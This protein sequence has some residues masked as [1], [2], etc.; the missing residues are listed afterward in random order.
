MILAGFRRPHPRSRGLSADPQRWRCLPREHEG[1]IS[2]NE[3][4]ALLESVP[5]DPTSVYRVAEPVCFH[6]SPSLAYECPARCDCAGRPAD[7]R[8][9]PRSQPGETVART[10]DSGSGKTTLLAVL[11]ASRRPDEGAVLVGDFDLAEVDTA[12]WQA[13]V[14]RLPQRP[15]LFAGTLAHIPRLRLA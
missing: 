9:V 12:S 8:F 3:V 4:F 2:A 5:T 7:P 13:G 11:L 1:L 6:A 15:L 10:G 14:A